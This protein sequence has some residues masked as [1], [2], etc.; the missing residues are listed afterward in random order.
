MLRVGG[1]ACEASVWLSASSVTCRVA[2]GA[3]GYLRVVITVGKCVG[4]G[5]CL[6]TLSL[7]FSYYTPR[8]T[9]AVPANLAAGG[10]AGG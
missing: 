5:A 3:G 7:A 8:A 10:A 6:S 1:T 4:D 9:A 2:Q